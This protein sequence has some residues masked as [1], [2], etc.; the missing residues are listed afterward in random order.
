MLG[1]LTIPN[2]V[3]DFEDTTALADGGWVRT[4]K[5]DQ[6]TTHDVVH[7]QFSADGPP[8]GDAEIVSTNSSGAQIGS[9]VVTLEDGG[10]IVV[11]QSNHKD[12]RHQKAI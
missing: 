2:E 1:F 8:L 3:G 6:Y 4:L 12:L 11:W 9:N 7:W 10:W 5:P